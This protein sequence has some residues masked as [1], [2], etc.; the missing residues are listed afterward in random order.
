MTNPPAPDDR[1]VHDRVPEAA[2]AAAFAVAIPRARIGRILEDDEVGF[3]FEYDDTRGQK[4]LMRLDALTYEGA[5]REAR[6]FLGI[7]PDDR[8]ADGSRWE[9]E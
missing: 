4:N 6:S 8:D 2:D 3:G 7:Q 9:I 1:T 5:I